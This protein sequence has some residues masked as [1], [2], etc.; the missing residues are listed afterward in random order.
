[1]AMPFVSETK[2]K[3]VEAIGVGTIGCVS[4]VNPG[5]FVSVEK[6]VEALRKF[7]AGQH[8]MFIVEHA[9]GVIELQGELAACCDKRSWGAVTQLAARRGYIERVKGMYFPA[10]SSNS[11]EKPCYRKG[12]SA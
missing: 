11:S 7:A 2:R 4:V 6:A 3:A 9:R 12:Q 10:V 5:T 8:G 1:M